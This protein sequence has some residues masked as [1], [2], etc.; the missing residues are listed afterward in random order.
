M[1]TPANLVHETSVS[2]GS[3]NLTLIAVNGKQRFSTAFGTGVTTNVFDYFISNR[4]AAEWER[5]TGHMSDAT[6]FVRDTVLESSNG[7][8]AVNF[9]AGTKDVANDIPAAEQVRADGQCQ[10]SKV[11]S[12]LVLSPRDGNKL[13]INGVAQTVPDAG[14]SLAPTSLSV[15]TLYYIYAFMSGSTMT[16]EASTTTHVAQANTGRRIKNGDATRRLVGMART[17]AGPAWQDTA[18]QRFVRSW[19][20]DNG[21]IAV[22]TPSSEPTTSST[23]PIELTTTARAEFLVWSGEYLFLGHSSTVR[24][25]TSGGQTIW[26]GVG[27]DGVG[28]VVGVASTVIPVAT[29]DS[30]YAG[31][32]S[33]GFGEGYHFITLAGWTNNSGSATWRTSSTCMATLLGQG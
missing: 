28:I 22:G 6:T 26:T 10:L 1:P 18:A 27:I 11:G 21:V 17:I 29:Q 9:S 16:L 24:P 8:A 25:S 15:S 20:H 2:T 4:D 7:G 19:F 30:S 14:V 33:T 23:T 5:G 12:N 31:F 13:I 32:S 3:G